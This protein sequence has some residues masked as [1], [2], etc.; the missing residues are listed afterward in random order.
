VAIFL[1]YFSVVLIWAT[2]PLAIQWSSDSLHFIAAAAARMLLAFSLALFIHACLRQSLLVYWKQRN[3]YFAA[4][5]GMFPNMLLVY[6]AAQYIP[7]GLVAVLFALTPF[8]TGVMTLLLLKQNPFGIKRVAALLLAIVGLLVIFYQQLRINVESVYGVV[9]ILL[10]CLV[11]SFSSV[12]VKKLTLQ[13]QQQPSAFQQATGALLFS[14]P[15]LLLS[16]WWLDGNLAPTLTLKSAGAV[17]YLAVIGSLLGSVLFFFIL[18]RLSASAVSLITLMTPVFA[19]LIGKQL[20]NEEFSAQTITGV[21]IVLVA[22]LLY[23]PWSL[24]ELRIV[25]AEKL[26]KALCTPVVSD[27]TEAELLVEKAREDMF[28]YK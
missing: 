7:S 1:A 21:S 12:W 28:R 11:F 25:L 14:L 6:W 22:L 24:R 10:S 18:Q 20:A 19:I 4:S 13:S 16:W 15:G 26:I 3:I 9:G 5:L 17:I 23:S 27:Q 2:T 8:A